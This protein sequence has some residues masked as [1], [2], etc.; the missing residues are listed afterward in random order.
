MKGLD[1]LLDPFRDRLINVIWD[2]PTLNRLPDLRPFVLDPLALFDVRVKP[3]PGWRESRK[4]GGG[5]LRIRRIG[6]GNELRLTQTVK[7]LFE[8]VAV[9]MTW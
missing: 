1:L 3:V 5:S 9:G 4:P 2:H 6:D 7:F 8:V